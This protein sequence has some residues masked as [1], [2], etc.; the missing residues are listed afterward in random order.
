MAEHIN[1]NGWILKAPQV[2]NA[3]GFSVRTIKDIEEGLK[4]AQ[5]SVL[6][7]FLFGIRDIA[8]HL[9]IFTILKFLCST[10]FWHLHSNWN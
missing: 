7:T 10:F 1:S 9:K 3:Q 5:N 8:R 6:G 2:Q 4:E